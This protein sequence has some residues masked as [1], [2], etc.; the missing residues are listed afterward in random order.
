MKPQVKW[1]RW[2]LLEM[3]HRLDQLKAGTGKGIRG[4]MVVVVSQNQG[5]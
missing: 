2:N 1:G 3:A 4:E 5:C